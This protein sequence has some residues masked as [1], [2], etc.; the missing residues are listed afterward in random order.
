MILKICAFAV[1]VFLF[2]SPVI[3]QDID[4]SVSDFDYNFGSTSVHKIFGHD[5]QFF[6]VIKFH[7]NQYHIEKLDKD[8]NLVKEVPLKNEPVKLQPGMAC[9]LCGQKAP[10]AS[11]K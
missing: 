8:L 6:Y 7:S 1:F 3:S 11:G 9:P 5:D 4:V 10:V 2:V